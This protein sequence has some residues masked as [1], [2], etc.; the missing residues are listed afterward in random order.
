MSIIFPE[1]AM[2]TPSSMRST[3]SHF[4]LQR[5]QV[6]TIWSVPIQPLINFIVAGHLHT[7][8][9]NILYTIFWTKSIILAVIIL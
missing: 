4:V 2:A 6:R 3:P 9:L 7:G 5:V 8:H 1:G